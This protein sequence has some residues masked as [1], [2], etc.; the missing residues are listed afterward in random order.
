MPSLTLSEKSSLQHNFRLNLARRVTEDK[1]IFNFFDFSYSG[2]KVGSAALFIYPAEQELFWASF[3]PL[4]G[5]KNIQR[6]NLGT[7]AYGLAL[8]GTILTEDILPDFR[9][10]HDPERPLCVD[11][12]LNL[13][14]CPS[15]LT[16]QETLDRYLPYARSKGFVFPNPF[17]DKVQFKN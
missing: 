15:G 13:M 3:E 4:G 10:F 6:K 16:V 14:N 12:L 8:T 1:G 5:C 17:L 7:L 11:T 2:K 9:I